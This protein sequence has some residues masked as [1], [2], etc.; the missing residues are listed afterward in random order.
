MVKL[1]IYGQ[2][3]SK[4]NSRKIIRFGSRP[5]S[6]KSD[7]ARAYE[8][9]ALLQL[10]VQRAK[11]PFATFE[12]PVAVE[13]VIYY[14]DRRQDLDPSLIL[15]VMQKAGVYKNDRLVEEMRLYRKIDRL[16]PRSEIS[17]YLL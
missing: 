4:A 3:Y 2:V 14:P 5:A 9:S 6:I 16:N 8:A 13:I 1:V 11:L 17:V 10:Q 15:D 7:K 12:K